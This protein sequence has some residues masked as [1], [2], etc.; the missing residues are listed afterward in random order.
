MTRVLLS[1]ALAALLA[2]CATPSKGPDTGQVTKSLI[3]V[4][5]A[6]SADPGKKPDMVDTQGNITAAKNIVE[7]SKLYAAGR[8]Q[9]LDWE[10]RLEAANGCKAGVK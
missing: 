8:Q 3:P 2:A 7:R 1:I 10:A 9:H 5:V 4:P 6:C